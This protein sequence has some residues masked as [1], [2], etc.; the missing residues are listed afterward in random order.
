MRTRYEQMTAGGLDGYDNFA[1]D[2]SEYRDWYGVVGRSRDS[3]C[4]EESNFQV[5]LEQLGGEGENVRVE[6]YG[7][8]A[9]GWIEEIY[10]RPGSPQHQIAEEIEESL[11]SYPVLD[12]EDLAER[13]TEL[14]DQIWGEMS[15]QERLDHFRENR[16]DWSVSGVGALVV[17]VVRGDYY[18]GCPS[19]LIY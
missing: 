10:V 15:A 8:W 1:G 5:A 16:Q 6:R 13:E 11:E 19:S 2:D 7:H 17:S 4:V 14:A 9:V 3:S 18:A 12:D